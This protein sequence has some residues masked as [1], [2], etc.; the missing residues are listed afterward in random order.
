MRGKWQR[1]NVW[2]AQEDEEKMLSSKLK[3]WVESHLTRSAKKS[4]KSSLKKSSK[5]GFNSPGGSGVNEDRISM[6]SYAGGT[7]TGATAAAMAAAAA[8]A[9]SPGTTG[10]SSAT[11]PHL[12]GSGR[13]NA[14][15]VIQLQNDMA[16]GGTWVNSPVIAWKQRR[17]GHRDDVSCSST[18]SIVL[19]NT[20]SDQLTSVRFHPVL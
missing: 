7:V 6:V 13:S 3:S 12:P 20:V 9:A 15:L 5:C 10:A 4:S 8:V 2:M 17:H 16:S 14:G 1:C 19:R 18:A 11:L